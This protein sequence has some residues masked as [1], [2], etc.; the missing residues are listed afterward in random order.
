MGLSVDVGNA[1]IVKSRESNAFDDNSKR[2]SP[3]RRG[4]VAVVI[5]CFPCTKNG[6]VDIPSVQVWRSEALV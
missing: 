1:R 3:E 5:I 4:L 2:W 6:D